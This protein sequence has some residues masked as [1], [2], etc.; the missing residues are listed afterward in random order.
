M[1]RNGKARGKGKPALKREVSDFAFVL[2]RAGFGALLIAASIGKGMHPLA[3]YE[4]VDNYRV[5][6][7]FLSLWAAAFIPAFE[8]LTGL[9]LVF[10]AW[11]DAAVAFNAMLMT[12]FL[13]LVLQAFFRHLDIH[14]GCFTL[15]GEPNIGA[16]KIVENVLF[17]AGSGVLWILL[18][19]RNRRPARPAVES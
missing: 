17:A 19:R 5:F 11:L 3:F 9:C 6:G 2:L 1:A 14:C 13:I 18:K 10:G 8:L 7:P 15:K 4:A 12:G 16:L